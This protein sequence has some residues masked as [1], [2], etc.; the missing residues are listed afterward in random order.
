MLPGGTGA[1]TPLDRRVAA[2]ALLLLAAS[3]INYMDRQTLA[4]VAVRVTEEFKLSNEQY[5]RLEEWFGY[6]FAAGSLLFGVL[7]DRTSVRWLYPG[8]LAAWS[9]VGFLTGYAADFPTLLAGRG[10]L[11]FFEAAHW[12]CA[13]KTTQAL[14]S[15]RG[16]TL[17][18]GILQS[19]TSVGSILTPLVMWLLIVRLGHSW[20]LAFQIVGVVGTAWI[21]AWLAVTRDGDFRLPAAAAGESP[22]DERDGLVPK[23]VAVLVVV[24]IINTVWQILRA[25][26]PKILQQEHGYGETFTLWFT[27]GWFAV[28][29]IGC[30]AA[31]YLA[32]RLA[33]AGWSVKRSRVAT[34]AACC[35]PCLGLVAMPWLAAGPLLLA[36]VLV[37]GA[38]ALGMFPIYYSF[39]QDISRRH[40]GLVTGVAS[41]VAWVA[42]AWFQKPFGR[43][44]DQTGSFSVGLAAAGAV[45][46]VALAAWAL[47]WPEERTRSGD[48]PAHDP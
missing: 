6:G 36:V 34:F 5:G 14:L 37:A 10:L 16:R 7:A 46:L 15:S 2:I 18:N 8:A 23:I 19:G 25:W 41:F 24:T 11:G 26:V 39:T 44:A 35:I 22:T 42:S 33:G 21:V 9:L 31:G 3:A 47:L 13:L 30:I 43:L 4:N 12:P 38:G 20:R 29:D 48:R 1:R 45:T 27:A 28:S 17:G 40:Q 32:W